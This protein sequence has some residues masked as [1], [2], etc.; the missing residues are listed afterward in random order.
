VFVSFQQI[1]QNI[2]AD[3]CET[4]LGRPGLPKWV[5]AKS[6]LRLPPFCCILKK[7][8]KQQQAATSNSKQ[9][10]AIQQPQEHEEEVCG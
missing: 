4:R 2:M 5:S 7:E 1:W 10:Q 6:A 8:N 3:Y 9:H